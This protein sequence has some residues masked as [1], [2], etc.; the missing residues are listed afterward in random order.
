MLPSLPKSANTKVPEVGA[1]RSVW[2]R[3]QQTFYTW[4]TS[5]RAHLRNR[6]GISPSCR[7]RSRFLPGQSR[8]LSSFHIISNHGE[9]GSALSHGMASWTVQ[10]MNYTGCACPWLAQHSCR[11]MYSHP[12]GPANAFVAFELMRLYWAVFSNFIYYQ[13][14]STALCRTTYKS[15]PPF[16]PPHTQNLRYSPFQNAG[17]AQVPETELLR[18]FPPERRRFAR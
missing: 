2:L 4:H 6:R 16:F 18:E 1:S 7:K 5:T 11:K 12:V 3:P 17:R 9:S 14:V 13:N 10:T 15:R 8:F